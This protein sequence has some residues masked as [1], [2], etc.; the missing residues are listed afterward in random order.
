MS[1]EKSIKLDFNK[2]LNMVNSL[3]R[4]MKKDDLEVLSFIIL[5]F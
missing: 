1:I 4:N 5:G 3:I 2:N